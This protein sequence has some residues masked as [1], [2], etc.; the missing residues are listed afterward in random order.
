MLRGGQGSPTASVPLHYKPLRALSCRT[1]QTDA[2]PRHTCSIRIIRLKVREKEEEKGKRHSKDTR[3]LKQKED[4]LVIRVSLS[5][6]F[7]MW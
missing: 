1:G 5:F 2:S 3:S 6:L 7:Q 4:I